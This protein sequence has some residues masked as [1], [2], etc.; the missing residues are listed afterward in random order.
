[1]GALIYFNNIMLE[2]NII[3]ALHNS[4]KS[5]PSLVIHNFSKSFNQKFMLANLEKE[6]RI[7][8][9]VLLNDCRSIAVISTFDKIIR[10]TI[11]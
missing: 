1:M 3:Y 11:V 10:L 5:F 4:N 6:E 9:I 2:D 7:V 8:E